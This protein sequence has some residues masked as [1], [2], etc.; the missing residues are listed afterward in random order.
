MKK[1][2]I[3]GGCSFTD[4]HDSWAR[5][6]QSNIISNTKFSKN[7]AKSGAGNS[8]ISSSVIDSALRASEKGFLPDISIMWSSPVRFEIPIHQD[9]TPYVNDLFESNRLSK[10]DFNPGTYYHKDITG[11]IDRST[12][13]NFWLMQ[14]S[15]VTEHTKWAHQK[16]IDKEYVNM[17][18]NFQKYLW[19]T[20]AHWY[21]TIRSILQV[22]WMCESK[23][24]NYRF[25]THR[26]GFGQY[27]LTCAPQFK[28]MQ[29]S[30]DW[31]KWI[32]TDKNYGGLR[33]YTLNN[34][35]T[36]DDGYDNHPSKEAHKMFV[37]DFLLPQ[38]PGVYQ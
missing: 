31:S 33:E 8:F 36:W 37:D 30:I 26:E 14:C 22:Q 27:I 12:L 4:M 3:F 16:F 20:N 1:F 35:N 28:S 7:S 15:K 13:N 17:F 19:N 6:I 23:G 38:L 21:N 2:Y 29:D 32:F 9:E 34:I 10:S 24:W 5:Y 25:M 18:I 11:E